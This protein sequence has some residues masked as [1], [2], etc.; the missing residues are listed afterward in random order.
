MNDEFA[1]TYPAHV[2]SVR[3]RFDKALE[4]TGYDRVVIY[5]GGLREHFLDDNEARFKVNPHF[6][7]WL[8]VTDNPYCFVIYEPGRTPMLL[9]HLP[10]DYWH[11]PPE[12]PNDYWTKQFDIRLIAD[13]E[14]AR[15]HLTADA[16]TAFLGER[17]AAVSDWNLGDVNPGA[18]LNYLHY[19]RAAKT[20]YE[21][22]SMRA[23]SRRGVRGHLA[24]RDAFRAGASEFETL[25][26]FLE[27]SKHTQ[28]ELPYGAIIAQNAHA[29]TLHYQ[30]F[31]RAA[32]HER[33]SFLIDS[34]ASVNGYASDITRTYSAADDEFAALIAALDRVQQTLAGKARPGIDYR[35]LHLEAH[36]RVAEL[37][38]EFNFVDMSPEAMVETGV[39]AAFLPHGLGHFLGLQVHDAG[40][41]QADRAG[42]TIPRPEGHPAL[43]LTRKLEPRQTLTIE[44]GLYFIAPLLE[45]LRAGANGRNVNWSRIDAFRPCGGIRIEDNIVVT[46]GEPENM[47]RAAFAQGD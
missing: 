28:E 44:P 25:L 29:A 23:A 16:R 17:D 9:F 32:P 36:R 18:L 31:D 34:G 38:A 1:T 19:E 27:A 8:P 4:A 43:R 21:L 12:P 13:S 3:N 42:A 7:T 39:S 20:D 6:N 33:H 37:L 10:E 14:E 30:L 5:A 35:D 26:S 41:F 46:D 2:D 24:A 47:T 40:G 15:K 45:K 11:L 22:A